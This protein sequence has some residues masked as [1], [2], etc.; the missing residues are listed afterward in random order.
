[1]KKKRGYFYKND[2]KNRWRVEF[3]KFNKI[4]HWKM[5][6]SWQQE[7]SFEQGKKKWNLIFQ[8]KKMDHGSK[9]WA[10]SR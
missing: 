3:L 4:T 10:V 6:K 8:L 9:I 5:P 1:M 2:F 7:R